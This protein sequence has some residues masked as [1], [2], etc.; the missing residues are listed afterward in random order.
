MTRR[1]FNPP[2]PGEVSYEDIFPAPGLTEIARRVLRSPVIHRERQV[3]WAYPE[4]CVNGV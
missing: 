4:F 3:F 2:H 1:M